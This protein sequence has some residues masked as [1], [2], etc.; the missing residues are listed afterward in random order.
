MELARTVGGP[1]C[2]PSLATR[3]EHLV[4]TIPGAHVAVY[5]L[6]LRNKVLHAAP[7][8]FGRLLTFLDECNTHIE[9]SQTGDH[10]E[11]EDQDGMHLSWT[12]P[13]DPAPNE[14]LTL[15]WRAGSDGTRLVGFRV[16]PADWR[17]VTGSRR[18]VRAMI[19]TSVLFA[20]DPAGGGV[21]LRDPTT[22]ANLGTENDP[23]CEVTARRGEW[24]GTALVAP[25]ALVAGLLGRGKSPRTLQIVA[26]G[27]RRQLERQTHQRY[28]VEGR[29]P[30]LLVPSDEFAE[31]EFTAVVYG[32]AVP[33]PPSH[34]EAI[35]RRRRESEVYEFML[36]LPSEGE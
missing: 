7:D 10:Y 17:F 3:D 5:S 32:T 33:Q 30:E 8:D 22:L 4:L 13:A 6:Y 23:H 21:C 16:T 29:S 36:D 18:G 14:A 28:Q 1:S 34:P 12:C 19:P 24:Q 27:D 35:A 11:V 31:C 20:V 9:I 26:E 2:A 15:S 25:G